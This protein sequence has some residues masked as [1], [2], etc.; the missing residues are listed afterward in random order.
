MGALMKTV[1]V[2]ALAA[3]LAGCEAAPL[4]W[5]PELVPVVTV[6]AK[7]STALEQRP[8]P[9]LAGEVTEE[10]KRLTLLDKADTGAVDLTAA[11]MV[12]EIHKNERLRE[13][14]RA[15]EACRLARN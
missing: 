3:L 10:A 6:P 13:A 12:S 1:F 2:L 7:A 14:A 8:C 5:R 9:P 11:L 4:A 15:Y